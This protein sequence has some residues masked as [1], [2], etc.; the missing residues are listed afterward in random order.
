MS[1]DVEICGPD[2]ILNHAWNDIVDCAKHAAM[3]ATIAAIVASPSAAMPAFEA[4]F[5]QCATAKF[6]N[7]FLSKESV[8]SPKRFL[9]AW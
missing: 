1:V 3:S 6:G 8:W 4:N 9:P 2:D 7:T 5:V